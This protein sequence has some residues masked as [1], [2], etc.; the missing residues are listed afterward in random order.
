MEQRLAASMS[1]QLA[2]MLAGVGISH[3]AGRGAGGVGSGAGGD[4]AAAVGDVASWAGFVPPATP[5]AP[6]FFSRVA[7]SVAG[8][9]VG[10]V[11]VPAKRAPLVDRG[12]AAAEQDDDNDMVDGHDVDGA[13]D[14]GGVGGA[15][16]GAGVA[17]INDLDRPQAAG[18]IAKVMH[19][20]GSWT[21]WHRSREVKWLVVA[22]SMRP[23]P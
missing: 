14:R 8:G 16:A 18:V 20:H 7:A 12:H 23:R 9:G 21:A 22:T 17:T 15:A 1:A 4:V 3:R 5:P 2:T 11:H 10:G 19:S 6:S 13:G